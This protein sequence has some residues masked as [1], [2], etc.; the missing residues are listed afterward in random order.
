MIY[1]RCPSCGTLIANRQIP[2]E[3]GLEEIESNP[4]YDEEMKLEQKQKLIESLNIKLYC[5]KM[6]LIT[7]KNKTEII[8]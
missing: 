7:Y 8:K 6:R 2:Y 5:C 1:P 4:N 3:R